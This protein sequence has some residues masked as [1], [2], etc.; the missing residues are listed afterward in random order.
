MDAGYSNFQF[1]ASCF[2]TRIV[3]HNRLTLTETGFVTEA[4]T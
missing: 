2:D 3:N 4:L 1:R